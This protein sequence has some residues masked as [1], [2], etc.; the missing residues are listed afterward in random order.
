MHKV[1]LAGLTSITLVAGI[2]VPAPAAHALG[3]VHRTCSSG[4]TATG[5][6]SATRDG[7]TTNG[8]YCGTSKVRLSYRVHTGSGATTY[9][10][11]WSRS[12]ATAW[13]TNPGN[14]V[15]GGSHGV[16]NPAPAFP[17]ARNFES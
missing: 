2:L 13:A 5:F 8:G 6:S 7:F 10:T 14:I 4:I 16:D 3:T 9:Q 1:V 12:S 11:A 17:S 15:L